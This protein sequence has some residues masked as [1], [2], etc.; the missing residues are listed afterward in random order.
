VLDVGAHELQDGDDYPVYMAAA[1]MKVAQ[2]MN[3]SIRAIIFGGSGQ[4]EA[5]VAN[6]FPGV[7]ATVWYGGTGEIL[8]LSREHND[9]NILSIGARFVGEDEAMK[10]VELWLSTPFSG[11]ERHKRRIEQIDNIE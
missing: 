2:D 6:R 4:G 9:S 3:G 1:A 10:A 5:M 7:R 8:K 11:E